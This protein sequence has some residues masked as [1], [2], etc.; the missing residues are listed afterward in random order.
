MLNLYR[1][2]SE[3]CK[4][5]DDGQGYT[6]C[7]CPIWCDGELNG[8]RLRKSVGLRDWARAV[9]RT[10]KVARETADCRRRA[11]SN[12][13]VKCFLAFITGRRVAS[14]DRDRPGPA[15]A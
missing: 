5:H 1:R 3:K 13:A 15:R 11:K 14:S 9:K 8:K 4:H 12:L 10:E 7:R 2:H 6:K